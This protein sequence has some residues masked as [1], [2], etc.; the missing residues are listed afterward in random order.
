MQILIYTIVSIILISVIIYAYRLLVMN[1][2][3]KDKL[4]WG[5]RERLEN[6]IY[7]QTDLLTKPIEAFFDDNQLII[8]NNKADLA[9]NDLRPRNDSFFSGLGIDVDHSAVE[10]RSVAVLMPF[11]NRF[12]NRYETIKQACKETGFSCTRSDEKQLPG[13]LLSQI[14]RMIISSSL[15]IAVIDGRNPNVFYEIGIA[16]SLGKP[17]IMIANRDDKDRQTADIASNR[18]LLYRDMAD[19][20]TQLSST[21]NHLIC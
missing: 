13:N 10:S 16:H 12:A 17:V 14:L 18:L 21:L 4:I 11:N 15:V 20:K 1:D 6:K 7:N 19:L 9:I 3:K 2:R 5:A 8:T